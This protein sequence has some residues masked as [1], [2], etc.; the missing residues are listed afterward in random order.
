MK[1]ALTVL[2][3]FFLF[4]NSTF[5]QENFKVIRV[6][7]VIL[8]KA[9][10]TSLETG[11]VFS[12]KEDLLFRTD[13]ATASVINSKRG[14]IILT[15]KNHDLASARSNYLPAMYNIASRAGSLINI[16]DLQNHFSGNYV[17]LE[18]QSLLI[19]KSNFPMDSDHFFFLS[20]VYKGEIIN[21]KL[22][23]SGDN[24]IIDKADLYTVDGKPIP[25]PD[26]TAITLFYKKGPENIRINRFELIFPET[27]QLKKEVQIIV[28]EMVKEPD[29]VKV[30][31]INAYISENY[32]KVYNL[33][34][35]SWLENNYGLRA[36]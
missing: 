6:N 34:L 18:K 23:F 30:N 32:G 33:N 3:L 17:V 7:G 35:L 27:T 25:S 12:E 14:R 24:L 26:N 16:I 4:S 13:D 36:E 29:K 22:K 10:G 2:I 8:L 11:T 20:Y 15:S 31:E 1:S 19:D 21:K 9:K 5:S 28:D